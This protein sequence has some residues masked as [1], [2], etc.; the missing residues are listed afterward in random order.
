M[1]QE[2]AFK[3][4]EWTE[5]GEHLLRLIAGADNLFVARAAYREAVARYPRSAITLRQGC[6]V[7]EEHKPS[8]NT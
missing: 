1:A 4:E 2:P 6:R 8:R 7:L 3:V 5:K